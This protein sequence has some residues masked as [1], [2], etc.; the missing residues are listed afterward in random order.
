MGR[1]CYG[2]KLTWAEIDMGRFCYGP[3]DPEPVKVIHTEN[4]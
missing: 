4:Q 2:P 1:N 3:N